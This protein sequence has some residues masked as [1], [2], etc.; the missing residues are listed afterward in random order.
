MGDV[1]RAAGLADEFYIA[2]DHLLLTCCWHPHDAEAR[3]HFSCVHTAAGRKRL[4]LFVGEDGPVEVAGD[5]E[6]AP[7]QGLVFDRVAVVGKGH[8]A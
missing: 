1:Q 4:D 7:H 8:R 3:G 6:G 2:G 5:F